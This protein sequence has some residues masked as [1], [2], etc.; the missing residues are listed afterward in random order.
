MAYHKYQTIICKKRGRIGYLTFNR[1]D[2]LN[3]ISID[4]SRDLVDGLSELRDDPEVIVI[5]L[6]SKGKAFCA[7]A[8]LTDPLVHSRGDFLAWESSYKL[9]ERWFDALEQCEKPIIAAI[10]G[11]ALGGGCEVVMWSDICIA[12]E[13]TKLGQ[14]QVTVGSSPMMAGAV[15]LAR[16]VGLKVATELCLTGKIIDAEEAYR[17]GLVNQVVPLAQLMPT[18]ESTAKRIVS[19]PILAVRAIRQQ[20]RYEYAMS[21]EQQ[22]YCTK[23]VDFMLVNDPEQA[24]A[25]KAF[26]EKRKTRYKR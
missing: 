16:I 6:S 15:R 10:H 8:D 11:Y 17:I 26:T 18:A 7:G 5:I 4:W 21:W 23:Y 9:A 1:P 22:K 25:C 3:A 12:A 19:L 13:G 24:E 20:L 14:I 2:R